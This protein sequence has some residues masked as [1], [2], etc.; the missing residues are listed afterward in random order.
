MKYRSIQPQQP[1]NYSSSKVTKNM[2]PLTQSIREN[3]FMNVL[4][5]SENE[6]INNISLVRNKSYKKIKTKIF[7]ELC[8]V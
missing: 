5:N 8:E 7:C 6:N 2:Q 3:S 4:D 1:N